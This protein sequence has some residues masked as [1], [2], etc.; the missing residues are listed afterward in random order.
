MF[1]GKTNQEDLKGEK[2]RRRGQAGPERQ[3][4]AAMANE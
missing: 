3:K 2:K 1:S 4:R